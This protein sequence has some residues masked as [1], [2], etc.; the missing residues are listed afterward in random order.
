MNVA[1]QVESALRNAYPPHGAGRSTAPIDRL[2]HRL[3]EL[4]ATARPGH[5]SLA[6]SLGGV[7]LFL[8]Y[9]GPGSLR[10]V[11]GADTRLASAG[12]FSKPLTASLLAD[13]VGAGQVDWSTQVN[14]VLRVRGEAAARLTGIT[15]SHL[16]NHTHGLDASRI[17]TVP[18]KSHGL[19]DETALCEGLAP[20]ALSDPGELYSYGNAGSWLAGA[21]LEQL[22]SRPYSHLLSSSPYAVSSPL[23]QPAAPE[24]LCPAT[25]GFLELTTAQWLAFAEIHA[26][27]APPPRQSPAGRGLAALRSSLVSLP[28]W[29][30]AERA[31]CLG[32][33]YYGEGW[34]GHTSNTIGSVSFLRFHPGDRIAIVMSATSDIALFAF[35][36]L[37]RD[38]FPELKSLKFPRRLTAS[39]SASLQS[40]SYVGI[41]AQA[42]TQI[43]IARTDGG[44]LSFAVTA[45]D[46]ALSS[47]PQLLDAAQDHIFFPDGKRAPEFPFVQFLPN[48]DHGSFSHI[49]NGKHLWRRTA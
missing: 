33:K 9:R 15:F 22:T 11:A 7:S 13:V 27:S 43:E 44:R 4:R 29:S 5:L 14:E 48:P 28:G 37:F 40:N 6:L 8:E 39:E 2:A 46:P 31:A 38:L 49:W 12:C 45:H 36:C 21:A 3:E 34:F 25:G 24:S 47:L 26:S 35:S 16:L 30:P 1:A 42:K 17:E 19:I 18:R 41:Y 32:W 10:V 20:R 23:S